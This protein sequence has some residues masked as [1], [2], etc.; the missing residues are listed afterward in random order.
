M[1]ANDK[2][3]YTIN[4][5]S[6]HIADLT[7]GVQALGGNDALAFASKLEELAVLPEIRYAIIDLRFVEVMNSSGLG[8]LVSGLNSMKKHNKSLILANT[9][10]KVMKLL[11]MT[12][13][14]KV[15]ELFETLE[16][17]HLNCK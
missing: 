6:P 8:M 9:P 14:D 2:Y 5:N 13:L 11:K 15:F 3:K 10:D 4:E 1:E 16:D 17:A 7:L 12:H